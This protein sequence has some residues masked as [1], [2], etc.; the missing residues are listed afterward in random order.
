[1]V[2]TPVE[3]KSSE[4]SQ[5]ES[6]E[7]SDS[8]EEAESP[9]KARLAPRAEAC[10][11]GKEATQDSSRAK[12]KREIDPGGDDHARVVAAHTRMRSRMTSAGRRQVPS[13]PAW[14]SLWLRWKEAKS[15][16]SMQ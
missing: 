12:R 9:K 11:G 5:E 13:S 16:R 8:P 14:E 1:M 15:Q 2:T 6:E 4:G 7:G 10:S 3:D